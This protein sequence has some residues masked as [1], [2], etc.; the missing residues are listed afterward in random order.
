MENKTPV[1][2]QIPGEP[3]AFSVMPISDCPHTT[4][5][6]TDNLLNYLKKSIYTLSQQ[7]EIKNIFSLD[8]C[9]NCLL[10]EA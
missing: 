9:Q 1:E 7:P 3:P 2:I 5:H 10:P 6:H 4:S 8:T